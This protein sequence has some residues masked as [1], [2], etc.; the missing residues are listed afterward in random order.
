MKNY[1]TQYKVLFYL[2]WIALYFFFPSWISLHTKFHERGLLNANYPLARALV[3]FGFILYFS[4]SAY[5]VNRYFNALTI[6]KPVIIK[7]NDW[8]SCIKGNFGLA[9]ICCLS[10]VLHIYPLSE[11]LVIA[12]GGEIPHINQPLQIYDVLNS[13]WHRLFNIPV[14]YLFWS[15][16]VLLILMLKQKK[17]INSLSE[18]ISSWFYKYESNN[19]VQIFFMSIMLSFFYM[20]FS[21]VPYYSWDESLLLLREPPVSKFLYL[22]NYFAFGVS[23]IGP[24]IVQLIFYMLSAIYLYRTIQLFHKKE[25]ALMGAT[26]YLFSPIIFTHS[27]LAN[28]ASGA[29]FFIII[30]SF[31]FLRFLKDEESRDLILA[32]YLIGLGFMYK[33]DVLLMFIICFTY[34]MLNTLKKRDWNS[35]VHLKVLL[36]SLILVVP[37]LKIG[38]NVFNPLLSRLISFDDLITY[39][40]MLTNQISFI[41]FILFLFSFIFILVTKRDDLSFFFGLLFVAYYLFYTITENAE[42]NHRYAMVLYPTIAVFLARFVSSITQ[43]VR[44]KHTFNLVY[45]VLAIYLIFLCLIPRSSSNLITFKYKDHEIQ[46][47]PVEE[48]TDWIEN[49]T[50]NEEKVLV[51]F[52][53]DYAFYT[54]RIYANKNINNRIVYVD[55]FKKSSHNIDTIYGLKS[56][57]YEKKISYIM[58]PYGPQNTLSPN[59]S[60]KELLMR[61]KYLNENIGS[62]F[63]RVA[64][65]NIDD[66]YILIYKLKT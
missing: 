32:T 24:R 49:N 59:E 58:F 34:L 21:L 25:T 47:F 30:I 44:W 64:R 4:I 9:A 18:H 16:I 42:V 1:V 23:Y 57:C 7:I 40:L 11:I 29:V 14:Q 63:I 65:F 35:I 13:Y 54:E 6:N 39:S 38:T 45:S 3:I 66:N 61:M 28:L 20:Y 51:H 31:Y 15:I 19:L 36:L 5:L 33:R 56:F 53:P 12:G 17:M 48:A 37:W 46:Y 2:S 43:K 8:F 60:F 41:I 27:S 62:E 22:I 55:S 52:L 50:Y 10:A 26:I